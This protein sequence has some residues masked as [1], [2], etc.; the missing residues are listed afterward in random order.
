VRISKSNWSA[1]TRS[2]SSSTTGTTP[3]STKAYLRELADTRAERWAPTGLV[4]P[5][6]PRRL[7]G[8]MRSSLPAPVSRGSPPRCAHRAGF[9]V[10]SS[11]RWPS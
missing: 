2:A 6:E 9:D 4:A 10:E 8:S 11:R 7:G 1:I 3:A 5:A